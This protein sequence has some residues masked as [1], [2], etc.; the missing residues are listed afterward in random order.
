MTRCP[1][2]CPATPAT[3]KA[4]PR[5]GIAAAVRACAAARSR[6]ENV[7]VTV[8]SSLKLRIGARGDVESAQFCFEAVEAALS[9]DAGEAD[10]EDHAIVGQC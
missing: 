4:P 3:P 1:K 7:R 8:T 5:E 10:G 6:P 9:A 2:R